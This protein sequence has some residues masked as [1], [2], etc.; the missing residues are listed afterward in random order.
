LLRDDVVVGGGIVGLACAY[1]LRL[2]DPGRS[3][4]V[5]EK[6]GDVGVHQTGHNS[7]VIHSGIYYKPGTLKARIAVQG[8]SALVR[9]CEEHGVPYELSGKVIVAVSEGEGQRLEALLE[10]GRQNGVPELRAITPGELSEIEPHA[11]GVA[12]LFSKRTG[13]V[14]FR[15]VAAKLRSEIERLGGEVRTN[16]R[17]LGAR[18]EGAQLR[19]L[20]T[21]GD[22]LAHRVVTAAG[23]H[24]DRVASLLGARSSVRI[25]PFRGEYYRLKPESRRLVRSLVYPVPDPRLPFLGVHFTRGIDGEVEAGPN[26]VLALAREGYRKTDV[27]LKDLW[28]LA[29]FP[30]FF[31]MAG[32]HFR[33][34]LHEYHRS[35]SRSVFARS[36]QRLIPEIT[37][38]DLEEGGSGVRAMAVESDGSLVDDFRVV[39]ADAAVHVLNAPSPA[40]TS[41]LAIADHVVDLA[42]R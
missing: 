39:R 2:R 10:R 17:V 41:A 37:E 12:A 7:G 31:R 26:A 4:V 15:A 23:L 19:L 9:F 11:R 20:T 1:K 38:A 24:S 40:A 21:A 18:P 32:R 33:I 27:N 16:A 28:E 29:R 35:F 34:G 42:S 3:L 8:A 22:F 5:L 13:V 30:G 25:L 14:S 6:E 36:L